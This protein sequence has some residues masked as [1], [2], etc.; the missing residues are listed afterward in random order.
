MVSG[1]EFVVNEVLIAEVS[2]LPNEGEA[3]S[4]DK[5]NQ[6][7]QLTKFIKDEETFCWMDSRIARE[8]L[9]KPWDR[10]AVQEKIN[11]PLFLFKFM[12][13]SVHVVKVGKGKSPLHQGLMK[14]IEDFEINRKSSIAGPSKGGFVR[15]SG[16]PISKAYLLLGPALSSPLLVSGDM[17]TD[18]KGDYGSPERNFPTINPKEKGSRKRKP[19]AQV[20]SANI[21]KCSRRSSKLHRKT[22]GKIKLM[23]DVESSEEDRKS[24]DPGSL[25]ERSSASKVIVSTPSEKS[26]KSSEGSHLF[27]RSYIII[28]GF[29]VV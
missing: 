27:L 13:K 5:M 17:A 3:I 9:P 10:V 8:S 22:V 19:P 7:G 23:D 24:N 6:V 29:L 12:E 21:T 2:G 16:A 26:A 14:M 28:F 11:I 20:L 1:M 18:S 25:G 15:V 4:R